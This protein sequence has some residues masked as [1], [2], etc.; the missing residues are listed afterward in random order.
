VIVER[1]PP[2]TL[3]PPEAI[4]ALQKAARTDAPD[5][6]PLAKTKAIERAIR[7]IKLAHPHLFKE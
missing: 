7:D 2:H 3:L 5:C 4:A 1:K 6:D